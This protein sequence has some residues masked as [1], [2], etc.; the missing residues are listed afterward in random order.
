MSH[1]GE[2]VFIFGGTLGIGAAVARQL[3]VR[4]AKV[5]VFARNPPEGATDPSFYRLDLTDPVACHAVIR[6][7]V[8]RHG[9]PR[10]VLNFV[11]RTESAFFLDYKEQDFEAQMRVNYLAS[12]WLARA[13]VP[14]LLTRP[15][16]RL[17]FC[18]SLLGL[19]GHA[20]F[21]AYAASKHALTAF[22]ECLR[23]E[24]GDRGLSVSVLCPP[25]TDTPGW[26]DENL[27]KPPVILK[28]ELRGGLN[29]ADAAAAALIRRL[30]RSDLVILT[31]LRSRVIAGGK[32]L[33]PNRLWSR[34]VKLKA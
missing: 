27:R 3:R 10:Y 21:A 8:A 28:A 22:A 24:Y 7:A 30:D 4:G 34:L 9:V 19:F 20:G 31:D 26:H 1:S 12:V 25:S 16:T 32:R 33:L 13:I 2:L 17:I 23:L 6:E 14:H 11:G 29:S 15:S 18:S 5:V